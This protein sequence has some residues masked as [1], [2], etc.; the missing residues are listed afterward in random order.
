MKKITTMETCHHLDAVYG[1]NVMLVQMIQKWYQRF[2]AWWESSDDEPCSGHPTEVHTNENRR[3]EK[4]ILSDQ[5]V[6]VTEL[7]VA[8]ALAS[9]QIH[10]FIHEL[11]FRKMYAGWVPKMLTEDYLMKKRSSVLEFLM[12]YHCDAS[13]IQWFMTGAEILIN[14]NS[15]ILVSFD[16]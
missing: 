2:K 6:T 5:C 16:M 7:E 12:L 1:E 8:I 14:H 10:Q 3:V 15:L 9:C 13:F 11:G 4:L